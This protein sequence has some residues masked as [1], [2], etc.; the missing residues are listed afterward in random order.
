MQQKSKDSARIE[1][2]ELHTAPRRPHDPREQDGI[3]PRHQSPRLSARA[4][5]RREG[6]RGVEQHRAVLG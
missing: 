4:G 1:R 6:G 5:A 3:L 2:V